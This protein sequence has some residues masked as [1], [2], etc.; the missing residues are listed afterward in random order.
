MAIEAIIRGC[1]PSQKVHLNPMTLDERRPLLRWSQSTKNYMPFPF[2]VSVI[3]SMMYHNTSIASFDLRPLVLSHPQH[4]LPH[5]SHGT[6]IQKSGKLN[7]TT[8]KEVSLPGR[9][10]LIVCLTYF[11][12][13]V[14]HWQWQTEVSI[15]SH[16][17]FVRKNW[18]P[19]IL[20]WTNARDEGP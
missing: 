4:L 13:V 8:D 5:R 7:P 3:G 15:F 11:T 9:I 2:V 18:T 6:Y 12:P 19:L 14:L 1:D 16:L 20:Y 10:K 17:M